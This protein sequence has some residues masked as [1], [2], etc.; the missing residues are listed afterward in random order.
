MSLPLLPWPAPRATVVALAAV[1]ALFAAT[2]LHYYFSYRSATTRADAAETRAAQATA[3]AAVL[4][5]TLDTQNAAVALLNKKLASKDQE[6]RAAKQAARRVASD[7]ER[8]VAQ[9]KAAQVP[10]DC[11][12]AAGWLYEQLQGEQ[13]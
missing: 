6:M 1:A 13:R 3:Q 11:D 5:S 8:V 9:L 4:A 12:A 10:A 2:A 7:S